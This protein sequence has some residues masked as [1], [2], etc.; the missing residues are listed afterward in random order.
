MCHQSDRKKNRPLELGQSKSSKPY[1]N[2]RNEIVSAK[3]NHPP[4]GKCL[5]CLQLT[6]KKSGT[7]NEE[8]PK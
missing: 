6:S 5:N 8:A 7:N 3:C 4:G 2:K 1:I